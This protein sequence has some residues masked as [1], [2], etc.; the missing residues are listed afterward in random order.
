MTNFKEQR[1][2]VW[3][4]AGAASAV[5]WKLASEKY[6]ID[7]VSYQKANQIAKTYKADKEKDLKQRYKTLDGEIE[8]LEQR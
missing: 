3:V 4:S 1:I 6:G 5:A 8:K 2:V 7:K